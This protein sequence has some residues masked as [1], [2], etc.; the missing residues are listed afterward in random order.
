MIR[1]TKQHIITQVRW[2]SKKYLLQQGCTTFESP[3]GLGKAYKKSDSSETK[4]LQKQIT[5]WYAP[6][7][8]HFWVS[9]HCHHISHEFFI[10]TLQTLFTITQ[11]GRLH[12]VETNNTS[13]CSSVYI[14]S[15]IFWW[16]CPFCSKAIEL[17]CQIESGSIMTS[18][19]CQ[20]FNS[21]PLLKNGKTT[22]SNTKKFQKVRTTVIVR[23]KVIIGALYWY[24]CVLSG[25]FWVT[26]MPD[27]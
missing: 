20:E 21:F 8:H 27:R 18:A 23:G 9:Q 25:G 10:T 11:K 16:S 2:A 5:L 1:S 12:Y 24:I 17:H 26:L 22:K 3:L 14:C 6:T 15:Y 4:N 7:E 19:K 13:K